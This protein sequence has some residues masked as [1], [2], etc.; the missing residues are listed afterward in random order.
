M[1]ASRDSGR[2]VAG[3]LA[4]HIPVLGRPTVEFLAVRAGGVYIDAT[5]GAGGHT[6]DILAAANCNVIGI[7]R[8]QSAI[9]LGADLVRAAGGRLVLVEDKFSNLEAVARGCGYDAID[10]VVFDLGVSSMQLDEAAR[11]FS[12]RHDGPLDMRMGRDGPTAAD[13]V[14]SAS[15]REL[16]AIFA[17]LGEER[18]ARSIARAIVAARRDAPI[19][20]TRALADIITGIVH[21]RPGAIHPATRTFQALRIFVNEELAELAA[22]LAAAERAL[23]PGGRLV[24]VAFHSLEDRFAKSFLV[25]RGRPSAPSRHRP[26]P[27]QAAAT[28][29]ILTNRPIMPVEAV[30]GA[31]VL[32]A[33]DVYKI[34]F[35]S[36]RQAQRVAKLRLEIRR[37]RDAVAALRAEWAKLDNPARIQDLARRHLVLTPV[38]SRQ[39]DPLDNLPERPPDLVPV[40]APDPIGTVIANPE[41]LDRPAT[42]SV[43][44]ATR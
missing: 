32:A 10:G 39:I 7:D 37:E 20:T 25:E 3:G 23:K 24:V 40:D 17:T 14:A 18:R 9:A 4:R 43:P 12:F 34:K 8:D 31:L 36:T 26:A 29:R 6:R 27:A 42:G 5:F 38:D 22:G 15:E 16:A 19:H 1:M 30:I 28:F 13:I 11:G 41:V 35:E 33:A 21:A 2:A 44:A